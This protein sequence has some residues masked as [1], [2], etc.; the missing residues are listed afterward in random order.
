LVLKLVLKFVLNL[1]LKQVAKTCF[2]ISC[3]VLLAISCYILQIISYASR[4]ATLSGKPGQQ[5]LAVRSVVTW[6]F[7]LVA[8][9]NP[10]W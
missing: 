7:C 2:F 3:D 10:I 9:G 5:R 6:Q 8:L 1:V 4:A